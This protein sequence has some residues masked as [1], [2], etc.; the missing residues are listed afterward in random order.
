[1]SKFCRNCGSQMAQ[2]EKFCA[3]CGTKFESNVKTVENYSKE[4]LTSEV[5]ALKI[6]KP[7]LVIGIFVILFCLFISCFIINS[8]NRQNRENTVVEATVTNCV[9]TY[10]EYDIVDGGYD[11]EYRISVKYTYN[12]ENCESYVYSSSEKS[13]GKKIKIHI[14]PDNPIETDGIYGGLTDYIAPIIFCAIPFSLLGVYLII[15]AFKN[16]NSARLGV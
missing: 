4:Q 11:R 6:N 7:K 8:E 3:I 12:G 2:D 16:R 13:K 1:M 5:T 9:M 14:N 10:E 15:S